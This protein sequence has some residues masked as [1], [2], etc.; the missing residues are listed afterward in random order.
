MDSGHG[1]KKE[2]EK[3]GSIPLSA[4]LYKSQMATQ[5]VLGI[6][7]CAGVAESVI[8]PLHGKTALPAL[9][10]SF[11][12]PAFLSSSCSLPPSLPLP[13]SPTCVCVYLRKGLAAIAWAILKL[14]M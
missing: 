9:P 12:S 14:V 13:H 3:T 6:Q 2:T 4:A 5:A 1:E 7:L 11:Y 10:F 8:G